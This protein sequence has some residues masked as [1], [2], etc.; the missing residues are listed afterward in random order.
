MEPTT[1]KDGYSKDYR[2]EHELMRRQ[3]WIQA[4]SLT[5]NANDCKSPETA[6][7]YANKALKEFDTLFEEIK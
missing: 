5:A 3:L 6:T 7:S 4:W 2:K 1:T